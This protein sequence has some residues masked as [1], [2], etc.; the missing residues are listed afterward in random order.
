MNEMETLMS[1]LAQCFM[2]YLNNECLM[3]AYY[4]YYMQSFPIINHGSVAILCAFPRL[5]MI[6]L[7][8]IPRNAMTGFNIYDSRFVFGR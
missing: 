3:H 8:Q 7:E 6:S 5:R 1:A 2:C 4:Y